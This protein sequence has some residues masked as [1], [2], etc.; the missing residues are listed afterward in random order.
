[1][2]AV[3]AV[4]V[5]VLG[6]PLGFVA[7]RV[8][9]D[10]A[11]RALDREADNVG[12][13]IDD[14]LERG[15]SPD[16]AGIARVV[17]PDRRVEVVDRAGDRVVVG[18]MPRGR[19]LQTTI[20]T[21]QGATISVIAPA[22]ETDTRAR[23]G[24]L[25][26]LGL[27]GGAIAAAVVVASV[28]TGRLARPLDDLASASARLGAGDFSRVAPRSGLAEVDAVAD[29]L[30]A[31]ASRIGDLVRTER[32]FASNASHQLRTP[33]TA[34]RIRLEEAVATDDRDE[35]RIE[36]EA[37]L[38]EAD[39]LE[40]TITALLAIARGRTPDVVRD[41]DVSDVVG[42]WAARWRAVLAKHDRRLVVVGP[43]EHVGAAGSEAVLTQVLDVLAENAVRH[44]RGSITVE[45]R[46][47]SGHPS[48][49]VRDE[50]PGIVPGMER[51]IFERHVSS[52]GS[53]GVGLALAR[54]LAESTGGR[55]ELVAARPATFELYLSG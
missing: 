34:L 48:V 13:A 16:A 6:V 4:A 44:G 51:T 17:R 45:V 1:M 15:A 32:E 19:T 22:G 43:T 39:R 2:V 14:Q 23:R 30:D 18:R 24:W 41:I 52:S 54:E 3:A 25:L 28:E 50:G 35:A 38:H 10:D 37:A 36:E 46:N 11:V 12:F 8:V 53:T 47:A 31:S 5:V 55:L 7:A 29:A 20:R 40:E 42:R 27:A 49:R 33:L 21:A 26:V 9:R